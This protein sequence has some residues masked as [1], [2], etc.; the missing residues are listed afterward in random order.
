MAPAQLNATKRLNFHG[1]PSQILDGNRK[2]LIVYAGNARAA[3]LIRTSLL[4]HENVCSRKP[5]VSFPPGTGA[6]GENKSLSL[7]SNHCS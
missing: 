3:V 4:L 1:R 2:I 6:R 7:P 5:I